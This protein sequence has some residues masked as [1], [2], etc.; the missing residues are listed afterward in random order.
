MDEET[1]LEVL[2][3][4]LETVVLL[5]EGAIVGHKATQLLIKTTDDATKTR[6]LLLFQGLW[7]QAIVGDLNP[8]LPVFVVK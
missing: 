5:S 2:L 8:V 7:K 4:D 3:V 6:D 1:Y